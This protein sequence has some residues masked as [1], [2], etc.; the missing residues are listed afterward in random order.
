VRAVQVSEFGGPEVLTV[1]DLPKPVPS[2]GQSL[3][4]VD[5]AGINYADTHQT[6]NSYLAE[7]TLPF[8]P[9]GEI[10]GRTEDGRRVVAL[11]AG[12]GYAEYALAHKHL[13]FDVPDGVSDA[14]ALALIVQGATA[15]HLL[16]TSAHMTM[17]ESVL[18]ISAAG[19]VG[20]LAVQLAKLWGAGRVIGTAS[21]AEKRDL[22]VELGADVAIDAEPT[23]DLTDRIIAANNGNRVDIVLEMTGGAV[24]DASLRALASFGRLVAYGAASRTSGSPVEPRKLMAHSKSLIGFWLQDCFREPGMMHEAMDELFELVAAGKLVPRLGGDYALSDVAQAHLDIRSRK[25]VGKLVLDPSK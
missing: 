17:G 14:A 15:W 19:G 20:T 21:S 24:F 4:R 9:G 10:V 25:T 16:R 23:A 6:E 7:Q 12:G 1:V 8:V 13:A 22:A 3:V 2:E 5:R 18:V 11:S